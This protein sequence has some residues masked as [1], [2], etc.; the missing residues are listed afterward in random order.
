MLFYCYIGM[1]VYLKNI[2]NKSISSPKSML[3]NFS[4]MS[5]EFGGT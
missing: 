4:G 3:A 1:L 2:F 5:P